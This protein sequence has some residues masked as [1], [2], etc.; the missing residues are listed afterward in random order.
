M[1]VREIKSCKF[2]HKKLL[3]IASSLRLSKL[4][5]GIKADANGIGT[6]ASGKSERSPYNFGAGLVPASDF[7]NFD[8]L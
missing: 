4:V 2:C 7:R 6:P 8:S 1:H 3:D 5:I